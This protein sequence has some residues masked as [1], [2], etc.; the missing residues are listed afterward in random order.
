MNE[1]V[2]WCLET[3]KLSQRVTDLLI[4]PNGEYGIVNQFEFLGIFAEL[5]YSISLLINQDLIFSLNWRRSLP[6]VK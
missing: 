1:F 2:R 4:D 3:A 6:A 5:A